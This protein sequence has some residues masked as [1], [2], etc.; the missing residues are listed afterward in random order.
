MKIEVMDE[1]GN[2]LAVGDKVQIAINGGSV[3]GFVMQVDQPSQ[4]SSFHG[5]VEERKPGII[6]VRSDLFIPA[7]EA[8]HCQGVVK[9]YDP[10]KKMGAGDIIAVPSKFDS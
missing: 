9:V 4:V 3:R 8:G 5:K 6:F 10:E 7:N 2:I 1:T